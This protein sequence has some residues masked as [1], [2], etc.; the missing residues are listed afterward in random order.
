MT[1]TSP[2]EPATWEGRHG[3]DIQ[4]DQRVSAPDKPSTGDGRIALPTGAAVGGPASFLTVDG[5]VCAQAASR[6]MAVAVDR[7]IGA[8]ECDQRTGVWEQCEL[9]SK[10]E[11]A[12][13]DARGGQPAQERQEARATHIACCRCAARHTYAEC[14]WCGDRVCL[15]CGS[16]QDE[17]CRLCAATWC[18]P[19][20][21]NEGSDIIEP[22]ETCEHRMVGPQQRYTRTRTWGRRQPPQ[23]PTSQCVG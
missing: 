2:Q 5:S 23:R 10:V 16:L 22:A 1:E 9:V 7:H 20:P 4:D 3:A 8:T 19:P 11:L 18:P 12:H 17:R 21:D 6:G 14:G 13:E 15:C